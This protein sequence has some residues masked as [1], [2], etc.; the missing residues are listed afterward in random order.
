MPRNSVDAATDRINLPPIT[1]EEIAASEEHTVILTVN[2]RLARR[3]ITDF[4][5]ALRGGDRAARP[6]PAILPLSQWIDALAETAAFTCE[7]PLRAHRLDAFASQLVWQ[8]AIREHSNGLLDLNECARLAAD[9]EHLIQ[10]WYVS[11]A[12]PMGH[13]ELDQFLQWR[14]QY[15]ALLEQYDADDADTRFNRLLEEIA[16]GRLRL[17]RRVVWAGIRE[18]SPRQQR[19]RQLLDEQ[20][21]RQLELS[22]TPLLGL[23][24]APV[25]VEAADHHDEWRCA[26]EWAREQLRDPTRTVAI[27]AVNLQSEVAHARRILHRSLPVDVYNVSVARP[28]S[29][30]PLVRAALSWLKLLIEPLPYAPADAGAALLGGHCA[31]H[32]EEA[33][34]RASVDARWR[35][36]ETL[37]IDEEAWHRALSSCPRLKR[38]WDHTVTERNSWMGTQSSTAAWAARFRK[39]L[40]HLG[41]PGRPTLDSTAYQVLEAFEDA[42]AQFAALSPL[43]ESLSADEAHRL[44]SRL[45]YETPFQPERPA[46]ARLDVLGMLEAEGGRWD[47]IW[48]TGLTD[49]ALPAAPAPNPFL[50]VQ[51]L[52]A[53]QAPRST[54]ARELRYAHDLFASLLRCTPEVM[55]SHPRRNGDEELAPSPLIAN[56]PLGKAPTPAA[57]SPIVSASGVNLRPGLETVVRDPAPPL[58][59]GNIIRGGAHILEAQARNPLWAFVRHRLGAQEMPTYAEEPPLALL[60]GN[61]LHAAL[62][63]VW[64]TVKSS[65]ALVA[66]MSSGLL[67]EHIDAA[68]SHAQEV[69]LM[70]L[71]PALRALEVERARRILHNWL[72]I[73]C[74]RAPF[75][76]ALIE[77]E[78]AWCRGPLEIRLRMDR[79]DRLQDDGSLV[80]IDYKSG[81][82]LDIHGW[83]RPRPVSLQ[84]PLYAV[85]LQESGTSRAAAYLSSEVDKAQAA[86]YAQFGD[87]PEAGAEFDAGSADADP[88]AAIVL[89]RLTARDPA[90]AG[91]SGVDLAWPGVHYLASDENPPPPRGLAAQFFKQDWS[92]WLAQWRTAIESLADEFIQGYADNVVFDEKD[93]EFCDVRPFL[94][95]QLVDD[96]IN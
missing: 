46:H 36:R 95:R 20:G 74:A 37:A 14:E 81:N 76:V 8:E 18:V 47:A 21:C 61:F 89:A 86:R 62:E 56:F 42:L 52:A 29:E 80:I 73:E 65:S 88:V 84:L 57:P 92:A 17:P 51:S 5:Q 69:E 91:L 83:L 96:A 25:R 26:V 79:V 85:A 38:A 72:E 48:I 24:P 64:R 35:L 19:L 43:N 59:Q 75:N 44:L 67:S 22:D 94:R 71:T 4:A 49:R 55:V 7:E 11:T 31:G 33:G 78:R 2:N 10:E 66:A 60:R 45:A 58:E 12:N 30:W 1:L 15:H 87:A 39:A 27:V 23:A 40:H 13:E 41:F 63:H 70:H 82:R 32:L 54:T 16:A 6:V 68:L 77:H 34:M 90:V 3:L 50:P 28:L 53:A 93:L 9:A